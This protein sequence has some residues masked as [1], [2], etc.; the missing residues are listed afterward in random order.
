M[1]KKDILQNA[2]IIPIAAGLVLA[3][4]F[5]LYLN[6]NSSHMLLLPKDT[7]LAYHDS[8][9]NE[10]I[11][12]DAEKLEINDAFGEVLIGKQS[13]TLRY[14][15]DY[16][17]LAGSLSMVEGSDL[18]DSVGC[19]YFEATN[20]NLSRIKDNGSL[21][22]KGDL[23][24]YRFRIIDEVIADSEYEV[25]AISPDMPKSIVVFCQQSNGV[26][27]TSKYKALVLEEVK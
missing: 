10:G 16:S 19:T 17:N 25:L 6:A 14:N 2:V 20:A 13:L 11:N 1:N 27:L 8:I 4:A 22:I 9:G 5:F 12:D 26:G 7:I 21:E 23:G 3:V 24:N 15:A 18:L